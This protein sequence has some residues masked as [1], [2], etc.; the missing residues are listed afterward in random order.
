MFSVRVDSEPEELLD[1]D[2]E[3]LEEELLEDA[4]LD[5]ELPELT[6]SSDPPQATKADNIDVTSDATISFLIIG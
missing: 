6:V 4:L 3:L 2:D 5:D 1:D